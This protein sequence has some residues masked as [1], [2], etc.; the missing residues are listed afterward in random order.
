[1]DVRERAGEHIR[2]AR[3]LK[4]WSQQ[5]LADKTKESRA[6]SGGRRGGVTK[7]TISKLE[8][9]EQTPRPVTLRR[10]AKA[11]GLEVSDLLRGDLRALSGGAAEAPG[12]APAPAPAR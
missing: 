12:K 2:E 1:M 3:L 5:M 4:G 6:A 7:D 9:G 10:L 8:R 11:L